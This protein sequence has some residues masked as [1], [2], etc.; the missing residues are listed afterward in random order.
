[1]RPDKVQKD[2]KLETG[3]VLLTRKGTFGVAALVEEDVPCIISSEIF[4]ITLWKKETINPFFIVTILN[5]SIGKVQFLRQSVGT[6]M[7]SLSQDAIKSVLIPLP[8]RLTQDEIA[9]EVKERI[10]KAARL[11]EEAETL[12]R[13]AKLELESILLGEQNGL[14]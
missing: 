10:R 1:M 4:K 12:L 5:S 2:I 13:K 6:I 9:G 8:P 7:G 14:R 11:R 3:N